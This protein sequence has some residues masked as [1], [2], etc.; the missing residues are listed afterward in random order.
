MIIALTGRRSLGFSTTPQSTRDRVAA[1]L[2]RLYLKYQPEKI[3]SGGAIGFD[4]VGMTVAL[5]L[6]IPYDLYAPFDGQERRWHIKDQEHY[7][8]FCDRAAQV[9]IVSNGGFD[10]WKLHARNQRLVEDSNLMIAFFDGIEKG[11]TYHALKYA[12]KLKRK[13]INIY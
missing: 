8:Y 5:D 9:V 1:E 4:Q 3:L 2:N 13:I 6:Q 11:G 7:R 10:Y 12:E